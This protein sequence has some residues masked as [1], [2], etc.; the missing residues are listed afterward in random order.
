L[1]ESCW[2]AGTTRRNVLRFGPHS[3]VHTDQPGVMLALLSPNGGGKTTLL[4]T[5]SACP[6]PDHVA[7]GTVPRGHVAALFPFTE[8]L[9]TEE[10]GD[11]IMLTLQHDRT[12]LL[13]DRR[14][15]GHDQP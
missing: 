12:D 7:P 10:G 9:R 2:S 4:K 13:Q 14:R 15:E 11:R 6:I 3:L 5:Y 8:A 1:K